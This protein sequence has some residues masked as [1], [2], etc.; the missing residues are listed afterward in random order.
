MNLSMSAELTRPLREVFGFDSFRP[1]QEELVRAILDGRDLL[2]VLATGSGKSLCYQLP[3]VV[4]NGRALVVSPLISLMN[5]QV[6]KLSLCGIP[7]AAIHSSLPDGAAGQAERDWVDGKLRLLYVAPERFESERFGGIIA[8]HAPDYIVVDEAHCIAQWGHDFRPEYSGLGELK[9]WLKTPIVAFTATATPDIQTEIVQN[10]RLENPLVSVHGFY[11][12]NLLLSA[13]QEGGDRRRFERVAALVGKLT[14]GAAIVYC[15]SRKMVEALSAHLQALGHPA[16]PYHAGLSDDQRESAHRAFIEERRVV[17]VATNAFGMGVDRPDVRLVIH[18]QMPGTIEAYYQEAGRAGRDGKEARC[19]LLHGPG[20]VAIHEFLN[21][22][23]VA[24]VPDERRAEWEAHKTGQ[25]ALMRRYAYLSSCRQ[26]AMIEY[27]GELDTLA[28]GCGHCDNCRAPDAVPADDG[29]QLTARIVLSVVARLSGRFGAGHLTDVLV[30]SRAEKVLRMGHDQLPTY[31]KLKNLPRPKVQA[32]IQELIR[33][34]YL[35]QEGLQ[36]PTVGL[37]PSGVEAMHDRERVKLGEWEPRS[38]P[39][40]QK[41][42]RPAAAS[43]TNAYAPADGKLA[44]ALRDWRLATSRAKGI[45]PY[46]V[47]WDRT[48]DELASAKPSTMAQL[49]SVWGMGEQK[50]KRF[51]REILA[52]VAAHP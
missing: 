48:L 17:V 4:K 2:G 8:R 23:S 38:A 47:F 16:H 13:I 51:G 49:S 7:A 28:E 11:R 33:R 40:A 1:G 19:L 35:R 15:A 43:G 6:G 27:F 10:L 18:A 50:C 36:Y 39:P 52:I 24:S 31:G 34:G 20:D 29:T 41:G 3:A 25:L 37:T 44:E 46:M 9:K 42:R 22:E 32:L 5:D 14:S 21:R 26:K 12:P 30:G 45:P